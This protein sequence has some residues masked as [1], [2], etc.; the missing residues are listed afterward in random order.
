LC[1]PMGCSF[2]SVMEKRRKAPSQRRV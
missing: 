2:W 1:D